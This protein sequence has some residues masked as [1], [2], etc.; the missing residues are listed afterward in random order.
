MS[1][2]FQ[3]DHNR[4]ATDRRREEREVV[5]LATMSLVVQYRY[6]P[7][8]ETEKCGTRNTSKRSRKKWVMKENAKQQ[9]LGN[10]CPLTTYLEAI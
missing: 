3:K 7:R 10:E 2:T 1:L 8:R 6:L 5:H 9:H 4:I